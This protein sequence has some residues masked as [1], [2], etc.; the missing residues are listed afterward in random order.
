MLPSFIKQQN[1]RNKDACFQ[2]ISTGNDEYNIEELSLQSDLVI[3]LG[4]GWEASLQ[5]KVIMQEISLRKKAVPF[6]CVSVVT[7]CVFC[8]PV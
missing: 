6:V 3:L 4:L 1:I 5:I 7:K 8:V 2:Q